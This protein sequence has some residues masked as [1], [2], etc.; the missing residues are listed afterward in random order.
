MIDVKIP[1]G[2]LVLIA[3]GRQARFLRNKG[4]PRQVELSLERA[5]EIHNPPTRD[6]G[7]DRPGRY[8]GSDGSNRGAYEQTDWHR[9]AE[10]QFAVEIA[11]TLHRMHQARELEDL[12]VIA[13]PRM[14][15]SLRAAFHPQVTARVVAEVTK[16]LTSRS[17]PDLEALLC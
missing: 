4:T 11:T 2:A 17:L 10:E 9:L 14:L 12:V 7:T 6:Q 15:G 3:D 8:M 16:E 1:A 5:L 13:P